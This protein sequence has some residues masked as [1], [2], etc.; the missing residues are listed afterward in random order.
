VPTQ[1]LIAEG[2]LMRPFDFSVPMTERCFLITPPEKWV[3][4]AGRAFCDWL[5]AEFAG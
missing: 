4:A 3:N 1:G 2:L 5:R